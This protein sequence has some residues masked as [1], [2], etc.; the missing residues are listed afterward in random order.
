MA[1]LSF[2]QDTVGT[3]AYSPRRFLLNSTDT[4]AT[5]TTA[6]YLNSSNLNGVQLV[7]GDIIF[8]SFG[9]P[10]TSTMLYASLAN[11]T[12]V[13][14]LVPESSNVVTPTIANHIATYTDTNGT[15]GEDPATAISGGN[16]QAGLSGTA[17]TI[18]S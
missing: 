1:L 2:N 11:G 13:I 9:V 5:I 18:S 10:P 15:L 17:G 7:N 6:G 16:V 4:L 14:T 8:C 3:V 12:N